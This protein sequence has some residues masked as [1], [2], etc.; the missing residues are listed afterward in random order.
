MENLKFMLNTLHVTG[1]YKK[2]E[3]CSVDAAGRVHYCF[4]MFSFKATRAVQAL[5]QV[6]GVEVQIRMSHCCSKMCKHWVK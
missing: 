3:R 6:C 1:F 4:S 5:K 2:R